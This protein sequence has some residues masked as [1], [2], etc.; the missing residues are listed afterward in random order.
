MLLFFFT[1]SGANDLGNHKDSEDETDT[2]VTVVTPSSRR[3][4]CRWLASSQ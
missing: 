1:I 2:A 3:A 4:S